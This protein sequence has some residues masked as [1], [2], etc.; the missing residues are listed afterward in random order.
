MEKQN[1]V[2][3][4]Y[5]YV[6]SDSW[7]YVNYSRCYEY[8]DGSNNSFPISEREFKCLSNLGWEVVER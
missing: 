4:R 2:E 6:W 3:R 8:A 1:K 5:L 7:G